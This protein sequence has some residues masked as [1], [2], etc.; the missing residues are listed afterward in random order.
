MHLIACGGA[1]TPHCF[2]TALSSDGDSS[3]ATRRSQSS[4][5]DSQPCSRYARSGVLGKSSNV[6]LS[7]LTPL[8]RRG[9]TQENVHA[10][11]VLAPVRGEGHSPSLSLASPL[12]SHGQKYI[13]FHSVSSTRSTNCPPAAPIWSSHVVSTCTRLPSGSA[14]YRCRINAVLSTTSP[15]VHTNSGQHSVLRVWTVASI[16][17]SVQT[18]HPPG[19]AHATANSNV[20][21]VPYRA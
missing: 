5:K 20:V 1:R 3:S 9:I 13:R 12:A 17:A 7:L 18:S 2:I 10:E 4:K 16:T 19:N 15:N 14:M 11:M 21:E 6:M 8:K